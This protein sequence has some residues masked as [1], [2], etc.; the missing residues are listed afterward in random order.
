M[1]LMKKNN[2]GK[3]ENHGGQKFL[4]PWNGKARERCSNNDCYFTVLPLTATM[5]DPVM[6]TVSVSQ[7]GPLPMEEIIGFNT[8]AQLDEQ[9]ELDIWKT[10]K[11]ISFAMAKTRCFHMD[12][13]IN[14]T[15]TRCHVM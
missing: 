2:Q 10:L 9:N 7:K 15:G 4:T 14:S 3:N 8:M 5:G 13:L 6:C 1:R 11:N 12:P